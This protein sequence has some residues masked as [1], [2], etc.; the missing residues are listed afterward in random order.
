[1]QTKFDVNDTV[2][3]PMK[4]LHIGINYGDRCPEYRLRPIWKGNEHSDI[5][6]P[7][8]QILNKEDILNGEADE[9]ES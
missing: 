9:S 5:T 4:V 6:A 7:E 2:Y 1:M 3:V 8:T